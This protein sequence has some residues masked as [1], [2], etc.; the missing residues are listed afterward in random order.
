MPTSLVNRLVILFGFG[1]A[2]IT[3]GFNLA[4]GSDILYAAF[5][6]V[7]VLFGSS[8]ILLIAMRSIA[9]VLLKHLQD[10]QR[11]QREANIADELQKQIDS[12]KHDG[13]GGGLRR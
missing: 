11:A 3:F 12:A 8:T 5:W 1:M 13:G 7:C 6:A 10:K 9:T 2:L 4:G